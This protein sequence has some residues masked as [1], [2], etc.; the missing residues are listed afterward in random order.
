LTGESLNHAINTC[1]S[2]NL[3]IG[4]EML[5]NLKSIKEELIDKIY[6]Y[7]GEDDLNISHSYVD[8][9]TILK[10]CSTLQPKANLRSQISLKNPAFLIFTSGTTG[11]PKAAIL[12]YIIF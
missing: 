9:D 10:D 11:L 12:T 3:I 7:K 2:K 1:G 6:V 4:A 8:L 5:E